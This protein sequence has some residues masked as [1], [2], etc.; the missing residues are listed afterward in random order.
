MKTAVVFLADGFEE[1]E[2]LLVVDLLRRAK[3]NVIT[4][5]VSG[6]KEIISSHRVVILAD[7]LAE[8]IDYNPVDMVVLPGGMPGTL[9]LGESEIVRHHCVS[10]AA[11]PDK[12]VAAICAAPSVLGGLG[13]LQGKKATCYPSFEEKLTGAET[14]GDGVVVSGNIV[15]G[16][17]LGSAIPFALELIRKLCGDREAERVSKA[18]CY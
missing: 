18:I 16:Q 5:S 15:T 2:G 10:F 3:V 9:N 7:E 8:D 1:C 12:T 6:K 4:A 17:A 11:N 14:T 13:L